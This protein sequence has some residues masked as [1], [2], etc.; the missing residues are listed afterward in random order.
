[1]PKAVVRM[2]V[3]CRSHLEK[4]S[5]TRVVRTENGAKID[6]FQKMNGRGAYVC[7]N[8]ACV[9]KVV[10]TKML[11]RVLSTEVDDEVYNA[12]PIE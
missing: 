1:M 12:L 2:C 6:V 4:S 9:K 7:K 5:L 11:N 8:E 10:K 3:A